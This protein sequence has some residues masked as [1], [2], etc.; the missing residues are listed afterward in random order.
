M[1]PKQRE[2]FAARNE[3]HGA[4][5]RWAVRWLA[6]VISVPAVVIAVA[7]WVATAADRKTGQEAPLLERAGD[8]VTVPDG[9]PLRA[10]LT[11]AAAESIVVAQRVMAPAVVEADPARVVNILPPLAGRLVALKVALGQE[12]RANQ[13]L[14]VIA[15]P[16]LAQAQADVEKAADALDLARH[17]AERAKGAQDAGGAAEKDLEV[18]QSALHQAEAEDRRARERLRALIGAASAQARD[19]SLVVT[20]PTTGVVTALNVGAGAFINDP[21]VALLTIA[22]V[23]RVWVTAQVPEH[24]AGSVR[25]DQLV[26]VTLAAYPR[27]SLR[28]K[29]ASVSPLLEADT[30]RVKVR[31]EFGNAS[32]RFK[33]NMFATAHFV[34][35]VPEAVVVPASALQMNN[36]STSVWVEIAPWTFARRHVELGDEDGE[37][38]QISAGL[39]AGE[40]LVTRGGVLLNN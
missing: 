19:G 20:A 9:S 17:A 28:G 12:V 37:N 31:I 27:D 2:N 21:S 39:K 8:R 30:R 25:K 33:P 38:V 23:D 36:D 24:L 5:V 4:S 26:D 15:S 3:A 35:A 22:N 13:P 7:T 1:N 34:L 6:L 14:L 40:R 29:V 32:G 11:I 18:A 16:D 10:R